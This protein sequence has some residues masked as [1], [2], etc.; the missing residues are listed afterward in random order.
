MKN[1][2]IT[3]G[4]GFIGSHLVDRLLFEKRWRVTVLDDFNNTYS[5]VL[6]YHNI[7]RHTENQAFSLIG[8]DINSEQVLDGIFS[9]RKFDCIV[10]LADKS[11]ISQS[12][13]QPHLFERTNIHGTLNILEAARKYGVKQV[14]FG[15]TSSVYGRN[16]TFPC[17]EK[18]NVNQPISLYAATKTVGEMLCHTYS[19]LNDI[20]CVCLRFFTIYGPRQRPDMAIYKFTRLIE[21]GQ[22]ITFYGDGTSQRDYAFIS[23]ITN[24]IRAALE[25]DK[26]D[27]EIFNL[28]AGKSVQMY[29]LVKMLENALGKRAIIE[30]LPHQA[31]EQVNTLSD[32]KK[33]TELLGYSPKISIKT[34]IEIF[35][36]WFREENAL[37]ENTDF[38][39]EPL[40]FSNNAKSANK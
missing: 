4:A 16:Q 32:I 22:P 31:G 8:G 27:Y 39:R 34:G 7:A 14:V 12:I 5:P 29:D 1:V 15:S 10:H 37:Y 35:V 3:G 20:R 17:S 33:A 40:E 9:D 26:S 25:Y 23:D 28:G 30:R 36:R 11:G 21:S 18:M 13:K 24:G 38:M 2:L 6:K 19:H